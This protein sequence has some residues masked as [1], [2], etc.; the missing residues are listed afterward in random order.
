MTEVPQ[1]I[2]LHMLNGPGAAKTLA[3][4]I[5]AAAS[6]VSNKLCMQT[7]NAR[8]TGIT[9]DDMSQ[10]MM[11][12]LREVEEL[13]KLP[14]S[15]AIALDLVT[16]LGQYS[17]GELDCDG[18]G[19]DERPSDEEVDGLLVELATERKAIDPSWD[20]SH[21]LNKLRKQ[22]EK[23]SSYGIENFCARTID[24]L[25]TWQRDLPATEKTT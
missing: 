22:N 1:S 18:G 24:L 20:C 9:S 19:Y 7:L 25:S 14:N 16:V 4:Q 6:K 10:A 11:P 5:K 12:F 15:T 3:D 23:L 13:R 8:K 2:R 21:V 17:Y